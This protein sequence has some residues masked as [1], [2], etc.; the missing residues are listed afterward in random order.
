MLVI[1]NH[2]K[3]ACI[4]ARSQ[5]KSDCVSSLVE[6]VKDEKNSYD[7]KNTAIWTLGQIADKKA[8]PFLEEIFSGVIPEKEL[9][10]ETISQYE[11]SKAI[12]WCEKGN[13]TNWMYKNR[14]IW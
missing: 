12:K 13:V 1:R 14:D 7:Q 3:N 6:T 10:N 2:V 8:L 4:K 11:I 9:W 5:Y